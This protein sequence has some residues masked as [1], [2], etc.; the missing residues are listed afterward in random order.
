MCLSLSSAAGPAISLFHCSRWQ[1]GLLLAGGR[2]E[3]REEEK[4]TCNHVLYLMLLYKPHTHTHTAYHRS[5]NS[6]LY[7]CLHSFSRNCLREAPFL[8]GCDR[9]QE[10]EGNTQEV[11][12]A[13]GGCRICE[14][15][16]LIALLNA[17]EGSA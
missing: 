8:P 6:L 7:H 9:K 15:E 11:G 12:T 3:G 4:D 1:R 5:C 2:D 14:R 13:R 17:A 16:G 10:S